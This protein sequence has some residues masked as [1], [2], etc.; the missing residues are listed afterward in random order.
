MMRELVGALAALG[1][2][3]AVEGGVLWLI[4][5]RDGWR[6]AYTAVAINAFTQP[7]ALF[8][9]RLLAFRFWSV[10]MAVIAVEGPLLAALLS[11]RLQRG[12]VLSVAANLASALAGLALF[13]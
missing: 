8:A 1:L 12:Y 4:Q 11:V 13:R 3:I 10:E 2:T 5:R 7:L 6:L 9:Y